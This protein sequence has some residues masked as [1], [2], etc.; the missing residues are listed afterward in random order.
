MLFEEY[1][2]FN[3]WVYDRYFAQ[4]INTYSHIASIFIDIQNIKECDYFANACNFLRINTWDKL[5]FDKD[6]VPQYLGL[7]AIQLL[8]ASARQDDELC[9]SAAYN[10]RLRQ[11]L[12][13]DDNKLQM[14]Y[15][16]AQERIF[17]L[18]EEWCK[19]HSYAI[20]LSKSSTHYR[21]VQFPLSLALLHKKDL[22]SLGIFF[23][24]CAFARND[25]IDFECFSQIVQSRTGSFPPNIHQK[26]NRLA[27]D[28]GRK[29]AVLKQMYFAF[30]NWDGNFEENHKQYQSWNAQ[31]AKDYSMYWAQSQEIQPDFFCNNQSANYPLGNSK[32]GFWEQDPLKPNDWTF[33]E[34][35]YLTSHESSL[36][37]FTYCSNSFFAIELCDRFQKKPYLYGSIKIILFSSQEISE[38]IQSFPTKFTK[39]HLLYLT[40]GI[41]LA[42]REWMEGAGPIVSTDTQYTKAFLVCLESPEQ[43]R[44]ICL[45]DQPLI[46]LPAGHYFIRYCAE[47]PRIHFKITSVLPE[48]ERNIK[49]G[50]CLSNDG[51]Y[52]TSTAPHIHGLDFSQ[53]PEDIL[54]PT[55]NHNGN[56]TRIWMNL[57]TEIKTQRYRNENIIHNALRRSIDGIRNR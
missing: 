14:K 32:D 57:T 21:Y 50:W 51:C 28:K 3:Q 18:F 9:T 5:C 55:T 52:A 12:N 20:Y 2:K 30:L 23:H 37:V 31:Q 19:R 36:Y 1:L 49:S 4:T 53:I 13:I 16:D 47:M 48:D 24:K 33:I 29:T 40:G 41:K 27:S 17:S 11:Y 8:A 45:A 10:P 54:C 35:R 26:W 6:D 34:D 42:H 7:I 22:Q 46:H 25:E 44:E 56:Q 38:I 43:N 39:N 15:R